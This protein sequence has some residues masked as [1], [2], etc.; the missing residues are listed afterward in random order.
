[1]PEKEAGGGAPAKVYFI[2]H[3]L[4]YAEQIGLGHQAYELVELK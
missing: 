1:M 2:M 4:D 3:T